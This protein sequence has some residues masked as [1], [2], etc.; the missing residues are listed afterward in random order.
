MCTSPG[1]GVCPQIKTEQTAVAAQRFVNF[2][3]E[4]CS[5][6]RRQAAHAVASCS[7]LTQNTSGSTAERLLLS[8]ESSSDGRCLQCDRAA[9]KMMQPLASMRVLR[10]AA[11]LRGR[12]ANGNNSRG[13]GGGGGGGGSGPSGSVSGGSPG[14]DSP[15]RPTLQSTLK[16]YGVAA[17]VLHSTVY[18]T[19]LATVFA[20]LRVFPDKERSVTEWVEAKTGECVCTLAVQWRP[21]VCTAVKNNAHGRAS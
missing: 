1:Q 12:G 4:L 10:S 11:T 16:R 7:D 3:A 17:V 9:E 18:C 13:G 14:T 5:A 8:A 6:S 15:S 21:D 20:S 19:T 2:A